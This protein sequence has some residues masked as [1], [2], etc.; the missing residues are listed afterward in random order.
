MPDTWKGFKNCPF[1]IPQAIII[2]YCLLYN[3]FMY[4]LHPQQP[5]PVM[6]VSPK[7]LDF[8]LVSNAAPSEGRGAA[9]LTITNEGDRILVGRIAV[10]VAWVLVFPPDFRLNPGESSVHTFTVRPNSQMSWTSHRLG[11]DFIALINSN[12]GSETVGGYYYADQSK[13][14][15][16]KAP[17]RRWLWGLI[18][19]LFL[20]AVGTLFMIR[21]QNQQIVSQVETQN[22]DTLYTQIAETYFAEMENN[23]TQFN[24]SITDQPTIDISFAGLEQPQL[25]EPTLTST[26]W[27]PADYPNPETFLRSFYE[28]LMNRE[29]D[30]AWWMMSE[31]MQL[32]CCSGREIT[33]QEFFRS[34]WDKVDSVDIDYA[35]LQ[36]LNVN[37]IEFNLSLRYH[38]KDGTTEDTVNRVYIISDTSR[39]KLLIDQI[40]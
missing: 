4:A 16:R 35:F 37:P 34:E 6:L 36:Q 29:Y 23:P 9:V 1:L 21:N 25:P 26:P 15:V 2:K 30:T 17:I 24:V 3:S 14:P 22:L 5:Q 28:T 12:G 13:Q 39:G 38:Y 20:I 8:G 7:T 11:S 18:P 27:N 31:K 19:L 10:Q 33:P 32:T 40:R